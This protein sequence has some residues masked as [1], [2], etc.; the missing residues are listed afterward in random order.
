[1]LKTKVNE[2][3][4]P[5]FYQIKIVGLP[6]L[7]NFYQLGN[8]ILLK[9]LGRI[10]DISLHLY[11]WKSICWRGHWRIVPRGYVMGKPASQKRL[12]GLHPW[13]FARLVALSISHYNMPS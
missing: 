9:S 1:M 8:N 5:R 2:P 13:V 12:D 6:R 4:Y 11:I 7:A 10:L 3:Q